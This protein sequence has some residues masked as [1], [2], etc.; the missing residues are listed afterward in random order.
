[1]EIRIAPPAPFKPKG[2]LL[3]VEIVSFFR[4]K[5]KTFE[6]YYKEYCMY[7]KAVEKI[8]TKIDIQN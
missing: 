3:S 6:S 8:E 2:N 5:P 1:M 7:F 4:F